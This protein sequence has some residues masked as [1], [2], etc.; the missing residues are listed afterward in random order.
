MR[1]VLAGIVLAAVCAAATGGRCDEPAVPDPGQLARV[2]AREP[3]TYDVELVYAVTAPAGTRELRVWIPVPQTGDGQEIRSAEFETFPDD[4]APAIESEPEFGNR[5][6]SFVFKR[7]LGAQVIRTRIRATVQELRWNVDPEE[8]RL[9]ETWPASFDVYRRHEP[10]AVATDER[11]QATL[12]RIV[13]DRGGSV[14]DFTR[15]LRWVDESLEY[16]HHD[17]SLRASAEHALERRRGHCSDYHSLCAAFG[18]LLGQPTRVA[19]GLNLFP[20]GSPSH[21]KLEA[22][23]PPYGWVSFDVSET[24]RLSRR[25][26]Q[27]ESMSAA[28]RE[29]LRRACFARLDSGFR[30]NSWLAQTRG[31]N[32]ELAPRASRKVNVVRTLYAEA[33]GE[34]LPEPDPADPDERMFAWMTA[35]RFTADR[36]V[37]NPFVDRG[38]L[39][40]WIR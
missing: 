20:K 14:T 39:A 35:H 13:P 33:D 4:Q 38:T 15:V 34:P 5:F 25:I 40:P 31:T 19:Y 11:F 21:C 27:D 23:L 1:I 36:E 37:P 2:D 7:P 26:E 32:Y 8:V 12:M 30:E 18:R 6:A 10:G 22:F 16:D 24:Q 3:V 17:A 28:E 29:A 9:P